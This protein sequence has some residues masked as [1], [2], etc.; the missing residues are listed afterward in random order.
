MSQYA[1]HYRMAFLGASTAII[2]TAFAERSSAAASP[3]PGD[4][5]SVPARIPNDH[6]QDAPLRPTEIPSPRIL[7]DAAEIGEPISPYI[8]GQF[9]EHL[10]RCIYGGIWAEMIEDRKFFHPVGSAESPWQIVGPPDAVRMVEEG[11]FVGDHAPTV[12]LPGREQRAGI[13]QHG[14][15]LKAGQEYVG[16][17]WLSGDASAAPVQ[18]SLIWGD[19]PG[20]QQTVQ[21]DALFADFTKTTLS[22]RPTRAAEARLEITATGAGAFRIGTLSLMPA[23][24]V[25]GMRAD[26]L[27]LLKELGA[28]VYRWPGGN[29]V[30]GYD[31]RDGIGDRDRRPPRK[32]PAWQGVEHNDFGLDEFMTFCRTLGTEPYIALN[33]GLGTIENA[34]A[35]LEYV[36]GAPDTAGGR[37]RAQHGH[38]EPYGV[39][40]WGIGNEMYGDWQLGHIPL[41]DYTR[42]H[43]AYVDALRKVDPS[44]RVIGVGAVGK[45]S[46]TMLRDCADRLDYLSEHVYWGEQS[47]LLAHV[48]QAPDSLRRTA[49]AHR[50]YRREIPSLRGRDIRICEDEWNY[51]YGPQVF[52]ECGTRYFLK[53]ALGC[54]AALHEFARNSDLFFMANYAQTV[55][56]IGAIKTSKTAAALETTGLVLKLYR[57]HFGT[58][59][60]AT[61]TTPEIDAQAAWSADRQVLTIG[62]MNPSREPLTIPLAL[63][64]VKLSGLGRVWQIA[65]D[66]PLAFNDPEAGMKVR[67]EERTIEGVS[68]TLSV[69]P[70][71][72]TLF[73]LPATAPGS[74]R[75]G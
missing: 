52:G 29:F 18:V 59:P 3:S 71:S 43:N 13:A 38:V 56:V 19:G 64:G 35:E 45:W 36:N 73:A 50:S 65:G 54:A 1:S 4:G 34:V 57:H 12:S 28:P 48:R 53:D 55:N 10:G 9:I 41:A 58:I 75:R 7:I 37:L 23:D 30:S 46:A 63:R 42:R 49:D 51:W 22:F 32:N 11:A 44:I 61:H 16:R 20:D 67:V 72:V 74:S 25:A 17:I 24:N 15:A 33:T 47:D 62:V 60:V 27:A 6:M 40:F 66:D 39:K 8:Y 14:L 21:V 31:W 69:A 68:D 5:R 70:C 2:L 26:T